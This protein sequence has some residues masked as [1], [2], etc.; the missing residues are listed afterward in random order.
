MPRTDKSSI[1]FRCRRSHRIVLPQQHEI[2]NCSTPSAHSWPYSPAFHA[3]LSATRALLH[4]I[5]HLQT[6]DKLTVPLVSNIAGQPLSH[7]VGE[8]APNRYARE[9]TVGVAPPLTQ[10]PAGE[11]AFFSSQTRLASIPDSLVTEGSVLPYLQ[12]RRKIS[13][14]HH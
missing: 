12:F 13:N 6:R 3:A 11:R 4:R 10:W 9:P 8:N 7:E 2:P 14:W 5:I 1:D